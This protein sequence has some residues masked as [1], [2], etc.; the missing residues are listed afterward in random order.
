MLEAIG[1]AVIWVAALL[2]TML[3]SSTLFQS[4]HDDGTLTMIAISPQPLSLYVLVRVT[5]HWLLG[6]VPLI[7]LT[8]LLGLMMQLEG[9]EIVTLMITLLIGT[10]TLELISAIGAALTVGVKRSGMLTALLVLPLFIPVLILGSMAVHATQNGLPASGQLL[11]MA[12]ML[13]MALVLAPVAAAAAL[14][15]ALA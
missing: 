12:A 5:M 11:L 6:G 14:R 8:P 1:A 9:D 10:P 7:L 13:V 3:S 2:A 15:N 4:D